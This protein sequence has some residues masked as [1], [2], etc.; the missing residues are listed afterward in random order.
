MKMSWFDS[1]SV[2]MSRTLASRTSRRSFLTRL[3]TVLVGTAAY[4]LLPFARGAT[5]AES[6]PEDPGDPTSCDYWRYCGMSGLLCACCG[7]TASSC[8]PGTEPSVISW[9]GTCRNP[10]DNK[11]YVISYHDCCGKSICP[12]CGCT[13]SEGVEPLYRP[14]KS[15]EINW[16][17]ANGN[18]VVNCSIA[19]IIAVATEPDH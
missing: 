17:T 12:R 8:P 10:A 14:S 5:D 13:R 18:T 11:D 9:L 6:N 2:R 1:W 7:G 4:P 16:C 3:G 19:A 15:S